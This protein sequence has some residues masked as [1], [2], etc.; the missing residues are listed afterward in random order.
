VLAHVDVLGTPKE[1]PEL[2]AAHPDQGRMVAGF[3]EDLRLIEEGAVQ[4][5][6][7]SICRADGRD[8]TRLAGKYSA[9]PSQDKST[10]KRLAEAPIEGGNP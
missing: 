9:Y 10:C 2:I 5:G 4:K 7:Q 6:P 3:E 8:C 1:L